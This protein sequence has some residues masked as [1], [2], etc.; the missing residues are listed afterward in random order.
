VENTAS[1]IRAGKQR[2]KYEELPA[3]VYERLPKQNQ[4]NLRRVT[5]SR[6]QRRGCRA[7]GRCY[8]A[9]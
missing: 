9:E 1:G 3:P 2:K 6:L 8:S 4:A 7:V 5:S